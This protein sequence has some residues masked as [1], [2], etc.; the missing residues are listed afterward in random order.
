MATAIVAWLAL[1][2]SIGSLTWQIMSWRL[3]GARLDVRGDVGVTY[4]PLGTSPFLCIRVTNTG[5]AAATVTSAGFKTPGGKF[6]L[7]QEGYLKSL[8]L[9]EKVEPLGGDLDLLIDPEKLRRSSVAEGCE[10]KELVPYVRG[11]GK[12][13]TGTWSKVALKS[14][15]LAGK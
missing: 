13:V 15:E 9:P 14:K 8:S 2:V 4:G 7:L 10:V 11:G 1:I 3:A 5:R 12:T 6:L